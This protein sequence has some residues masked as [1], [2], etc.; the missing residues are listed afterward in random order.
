M[1]YESHHLAAVDLGS[2]SFHLI[3]A[4]EEEGRPMV[5]DR[6]RDRVGL[7]EGLGPDGSLEESIQERALA[8]LQRFAQ[9]LEGI[10]AARVRAVGTATFRKAH[11]STRFHARAQ[12][13]LQRKIEVL[14]GREEA[15]LIYLGVAHSLP[16]S[17]SQRLV[18]DIGG[19]ST[20]CIVGQGFQ[21]QLEESLTM[22]CV[23]FTRQFFAK[24]TLTPKA[25]KRAK[26]E[27][28]VQLEPVEAAIRKAGW[29]EAVGAS[30]TVQA[31]S[32]LLLELGL[33]DGTIT[34]KG[35]VQ[36]R[37]LMCDAGHVDDL[38]FEGMR[39]D[40]R[41]VLAAGVAILEGLFESLQIERMSASPGALREGLLHDLLGRIHHEDV[42]G[43]TVVAFGSRLGI[44]ELQASRVLSLARDLFDQVAEDWGLL[45]D[46][47]ELLGWSAWLHEV[48]LAVSYSGFHKHGAYLL[49]HAD[50]TGFSR[51]EQL[52]LS[53][54]VLLHRKRFRI[55]L[56]DSLPPDERETLIELAILLRLSV[57]IHRGHRAED[58][59]P[60]S[61]SVGDE[62]DLLRIQFAPGWFEEHPLTQ[63]DLARESEA[64]EGIGITLEVS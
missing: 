29:Q 55:E 40:R 24:G 56:L 50:L 34:R 25:F 4:R 28:R 43:S 48:G 20:E 39:E 54:L 44:D 3:I 52:R 57:A 59:P 38:E 12:D 5:V 32:A 33:T 9:R 42:R 7:A 36:L 18:I 31:V 63:E 13:A 61:V 6:I 37:E 22:G 19:A 26:V 2:N 21:S 35:L 10:P 45:P 30:G 51:D 11:P 46:H 15:R 62:G 47:R 17:G 53:L 41:S 64:L 8:C 16:G 27:A 23:T 14:G 49:E 60:P 58:V 1:E